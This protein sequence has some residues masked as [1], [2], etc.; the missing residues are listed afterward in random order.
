MLHY[1]HCS[2]VVLKLFMLS[3]YYPFNI[4]SDMSS[5]I[6]DI[7]NLYIV[8]LWSHPPSWLFIDFIDIFK[9]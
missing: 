5:F 9:E 1:L 8:S 4:C 7:G 6:S 2:S 3:P